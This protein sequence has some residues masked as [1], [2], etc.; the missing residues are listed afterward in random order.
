MRNLL[1]IITVI[2]FNINVFGQVKDLILYKTYSDFTSEKDLETLKVKTYSYYELLNFG[3]FSFVLENDSEISSEGYWG[4]LLDGKLFRFQDEVAYFVYDSGKIVY[5]ELGTF[6]LDL[7]FDLKP[8]GI[9]NWYE[10]EFFRC[11]SKDLTSKI[12]EYK[13]IRSFAKEVPEH[14]EI[15][16]CIRKWPK[17]YTLRADIENGRKCIENLN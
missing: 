13:K 10:D 17:P 15:I 6:Y 3:N 12:Y 16:E 14:A 11:F 5:Y 4:F 9:I 2:L 8:N 1:L 7:I